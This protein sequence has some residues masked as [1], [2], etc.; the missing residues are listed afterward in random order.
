M[1]L[2]SR[3]VQ[4]AL[5]ARLGVLGEGPAS[6]AAAV[7]MLG[8]D[9]ELGLAARLAG[10]SARHA[11]DAAEALAAVGILQ[12]SRSLA[13]VHPLVRASVRS[14]LSEAER[15]AGHAR[16]A[17][18]LAEA[19]RLRTGSQCI[20]SRAGR[21]TIRMSLRGCGRRPAALWLGAR[22]RSPSRICDGRCASHRRPPRRPLSPPS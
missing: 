17:E 11:L 8:D 22:S 10:L 19:G 3:G 16:A 20:C 15:D 7:A 6:L 4:H 14:E 18:L 1:R 2:G 21:A 5:A 13:F 9:T 12:G